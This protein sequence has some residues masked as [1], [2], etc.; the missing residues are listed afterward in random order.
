MSS[1]YPPFVSKSRNQTRQKI[2]NW[3]E[4]LRFPPLP[5]I[6][7]EAQDLISSLVSLLSFDETLFLTLIDISLKRSARERTGW[8]LEQRARFP[9]RI[10]SWLRA[11]QDTAL[12]WLRQT[13]TEG[14]W[15]ELS[16]S[17]LILGSRASTG[18]PFICKLLLSY[19][20][21]RI[22]ETPGTLMTIL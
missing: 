3:R 19:L 2:L 9:D 8:D 1:G 17:K 22:R 18:R 15:M 11:E 21:W 5:R 7:R 20:N 12:L 10:P 16:Q 13:T 14:R 4:S 6:S